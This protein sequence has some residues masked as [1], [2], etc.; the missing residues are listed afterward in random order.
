MSLMFP[1]LTLVS[2]VRG[3]QAREAM[4]NLSKWGGCMDFSLSTVRSTFES[5]YFKRG[6]KREFSLSLCLS[7]SLSL[8][9][10]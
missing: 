9:L 5:I 2:R 4:Q 8:A 7:I 6:E 1:S 10:L 3:G